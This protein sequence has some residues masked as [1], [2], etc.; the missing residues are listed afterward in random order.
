MSAADVLGIGF[1]LSGTLVVALLWWLFRGALPVSPEDGCDGAGGGDGGS[2]RV[3][4]R[5]HRPW[6][7]TGG[8][9]PPRPHRD[10]PAAPRAPRRGPASRPG[11]G[12]RG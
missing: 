11:A 1:P 4:P 7:R 3:P 10:R 12:R 5:P 8:R 2:D 6:M 9:R